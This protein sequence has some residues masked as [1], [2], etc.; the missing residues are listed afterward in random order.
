MGRGAGFKSDTTRHL[1]GRS[2]RVLAFGLAFVFLASRM[3][4]RERGGGKLKATGK[5]VAR[6][7]ILLLDTAWPLASSFVMIQADSEIE[8]PQ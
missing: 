6:F 3:T 1:S 4:I 7:W 5:V 8:K 2:V